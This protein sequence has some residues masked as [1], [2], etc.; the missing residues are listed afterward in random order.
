MLAIF[1]PNESLILFFLVSLFDSCV[2]LAFRYSMNNVTKS[3]IL[4]WGSLPI[5]HKIQ[6]KVKWLRSLFCVIP[7]VYS[8]DMPLFFQKKKKKKRS[9]LTQFNHTDFHWHL[10]KEKK[11]IC[12][13]LALKLQQWLRSVEKNERNHDLSRYIWKLMK[14]FIILCIVRRFNVNKNIH[15]FHHQYHLH[16]CLML[17]VECILF[18]I[19]F[20]GKYGVIFVHH[21]FVN[22][23]ANKQE[24]LCVCLFCWECCRLFYKCYKCCE[25]NEKKQNVSISCEILF[26]IRLDKWV[27]ECSIIWCFCC[28]GAFKCTFV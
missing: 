17:I 26:E 12:I 11:N 19:S 20:Y 2:A 14:I 25:R 22:A 27:W 18:S 6:F 1:F 24:L 15:N 7:F 9:F 21:L 8:M 23:I 16:F 5:L 3:E 10:A 28:S 13:S 4:N